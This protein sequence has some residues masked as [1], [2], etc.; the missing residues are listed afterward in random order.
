[1]RLVYSAIILMGGEGSRLSS[2]IPKQ[3]L[4]LGPQPIYQ[5][6][7]RIFRESQLFDEIILVC[8]S[9][10]VSKV[11]EEIVSFSNVQVISG[12]STRQQSSLRGLKACHPSC[13]YVMIHDA[14]RPFV[15]QEILQKNIAAV[16]QYGAV[17]TCIPSSDTLLVTH[18]GI[19][20]DIIPP[21]HQFRRGQTPQTFS[22]PLICQAHHQT[23]QVNATDDCQLTVDLGIPVAIV[24][25]SDENLKITTEWD[26]EIAQLLYQRKNVSFRA[27]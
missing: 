3:F 14:V 9:D 15:S 11:K 1:M 2:A 6:T 24:E 4:Q 23:E 26:F 21:R 27:C 19:S 17:D 16:L 18:D 22:Y 5:H 8:H 12:G 20:I 13:N 10:W 7:L 25:G